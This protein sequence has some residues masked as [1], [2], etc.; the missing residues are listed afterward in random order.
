MLGKIRQLCVKKNAL[1]EEQKP[2]ALTK[3]QQI[4]SDLAHLMNR[5][6][7]QL[8]GKKLTELLELLRQK[9]LHCYEVERSAFEKLKKAV[10]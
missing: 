8:Q 6:A 5:A 2:Q 7:K 1:F 3:M 4:N 10:E 9:I